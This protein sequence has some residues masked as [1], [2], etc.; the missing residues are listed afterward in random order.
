[1]PSKP[2]GEI[3]EDDRVLD[4]RARGWALVEDRRRGG[5]RRLVPSPDPKEIV[6]AGAIEALVKDGVMVIA[7]GGGGV[8][9]I[10]NENGTLT[11]IAAVVDKDLASAL[12]A[13]DLG[14][15][16]LLIL[17]DVD[18]V[19]LSFGT[20]EEHPLGDVSVA[21]ARELQDAGEF[22]PGSMGPKIEAACRFAEATGHPGVIGSIDDALDALVGTKGTRVTRT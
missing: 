16:A 13:I 15:D 9:V 8:P 19:R 5:W 22:A 7:A 20:P 6:E 4:L 11:G 1:M 12:L 2:V 3:I 18:A 17:T 14:A 21:N 10:Q